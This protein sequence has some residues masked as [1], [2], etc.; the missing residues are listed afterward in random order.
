MK[1]APE[2]DRLPLRHMLESV[3]TAFEYT[4]RNRDAFFAPRRPRDTTLR[5]PQTLA[6]SSQPLSETTKATEPGV[7]WTQIAGFRSILVHGYMTFPKKDAVP[8]NDATSTSDDP[9]MTIDLLHSAVAARLPCLT[10][11]QQ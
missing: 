9:T 10:C 6:E 3:R 8:P 1:P 2:S 7:P 4:Q 5:N 11:P